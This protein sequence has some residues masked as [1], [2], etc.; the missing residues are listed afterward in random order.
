M[1]SARTK[2]E[3]IPVLIVGDAPTQPTGLA[4]IARDIAELLRRDAAADVLPIRI[5]QLGLNYGGE[6]CNWHVYPLRD[7][8]SW[9][10]ADIG[11]AWEDWRGVGYKGPGVIFSVWDPGRCP[12][13]TGGLALAP[14]GR[15]E[16]SFLGRWSSDG[17]AWPRLWGYFAID[18][19][20]AHG[21][22]GGP[23]PDALEQYQ[24]LLAYGLYGSE[25]LER[26]T[27]R[28][29]DWL[30]H[31][32]DLDIFKPQTEPPELL[33][34]SWTLDRNSPKPPTTIGVIA[35][36]TPR[37]DLGSVFAAL[38]NVD[39][40][41]WIHT[42]QLTTNAWSIAELA[43]IFGRNTPER[44]MVTVGGL[45]DQEIARWLSFCDATIA[46]GLGEG[47]GY[48]IV[49]SLACGT[50]VVH[51]NYAG[52]AQWMPHPAW[53][54]GVGGFRQ[55]G[56]YALVRPTPNPA[57]IQKSLRGAVQFK[58]RERLVC[59]AY[60]HGS[61]QHLDWRNLWPWWRAWWLQGLEKLQGEGR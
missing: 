17:Y 23:V 25:V 47:F 13:V 40:R 18:A 54:F 16:L 15:P 11:P 34:E 59:Q 46:P 50:P 5:A 35:T 28:K 43:H 56:A 24:R 39:C 20:N 42:H 10:Q 44:L 37:K 12:G 41:L 19:A 22:L 49:E 4:R 51:V 38:E 7:E 61:V 2:D 53:R 26:T 31:G 21:A 33:P 58:R 55:E 52:G 36:N 3:R 9:G 45:D 29:A 57:D 8:Q 30:P 27:S 6:R 14:P 1:D 48:P 60:C 32:I